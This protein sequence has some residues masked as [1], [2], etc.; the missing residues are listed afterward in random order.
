MAQA[1][2]R[3][4]LCGSEG[5]RFPLRCAVTQSASKPPLLQLSGLFATEFL[6][7]LADPTD[8][9]GLAI[10]VSMAAHEGAEHNSENA[11][12]FI[13]GLRRCALATR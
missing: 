12:T 4:P 11:N 8:T 10:V 13:P 3:T 2:I 7:A 1:H 6:D 5:V 9:D